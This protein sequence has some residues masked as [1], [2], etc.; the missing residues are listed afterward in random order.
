MINKNMDNFKSHYDVED[1]VLYI[2]N[3]DKQVE[4]SIEFSE[5]IVLDID[6][7]GE[8]IGLE[9]FYASE[10]LQAFNK[11][12]DKDF[13]ESLKEAS[14]EYKNLRNM[15]FIVAVLKSGTK[16]IS[17]PFPPLR[18]SEYSSPLITS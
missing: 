7:N 17:Q 11:T 2:Y 6:E 13:L 1:D 4:E 12:I 8:V 15:L 5:D 16:T 9:V 10:F 3:A 14:L 18:K